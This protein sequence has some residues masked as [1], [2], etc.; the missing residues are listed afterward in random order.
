MKKLVLILTFIPFIYGCN[1][2]S[3]TNAEIMKAKQAAIDSVNQANLIS[4]QQKEIDSLKLAAKDKEI[5]S[6]KNNLAATKSH[7]STA[8]AP[9]PSAPVPVSTSKKKKLS[10]TAK[11]AMIG[12]GVG[13][14][15]G[16]VV[17]KKKGQG[18]IIGGVVGAG[19]GAGVGAVI[20]HK[21]R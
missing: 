2:S 19:A 3:D 8:P 12:A 17:S 1:R 9:S 21:Q 18:A 5:K 15:T 11:G 7:N 16:A 14:I 4:Q 6:E 10:N 20:D 13:A